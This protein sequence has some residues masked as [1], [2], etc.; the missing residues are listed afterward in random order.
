MRYQILVGKNDLI[1]KTKNQGEYLWQVTP[2]DEFKLVDKNV[3][4][5]DK[6][7]SSP[8]LRR[9]IKRNE[10]PEKDLTTKKPR[11]P[12]VINN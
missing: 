6:P 4:I 3:V 1:L 5:N 11:G 12:L 7:A 9:S 10:T 8:I 2:I